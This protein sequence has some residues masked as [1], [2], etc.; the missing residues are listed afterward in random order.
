MR[1][2]ETTPLSIRE[3]P[4]YPRPL[5]A[6]SRRLCSYTGT[7][8]WIS[9]AELATQCRHFTAGAQREPAKRPATP[10][11]R[12]RG[13][14][15]AITLGLLAAQNSCHSLASDT[16]APLIITVEHHNVSRCTPL[17]VLIDLFLLTL[18]L[19][20]ANWPRLSHTTGTA[21]SRLLKAS[22]TLKIFLNL[23]D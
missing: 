8:V 3:A 10:K 21:Y 19:N 18:L 12:A 7:S 20:C 17:E 15:I 16:H 2:E 11:G 22:R 23:S 14:S 13:S 4:A 1:R 5:A 9:P 6:L